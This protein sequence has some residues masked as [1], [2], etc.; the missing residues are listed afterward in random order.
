MGTSAIFQPIS[1]GLA[2]MERGQTLINFLDNNTLAP[3]GSFRS[4]GSSTASL[5]PK[6]ENAEL[7]T[8]ETPMRDLLDWPV[9][10]TDLE[11]DVS[12]MQ[13]SGEIMSLVHMSTPG[14]YIT[15]TIEATVAISVAS[16]GYKDI[17][18][19]F[20]TDGNI[21]R[22]ATL[23]E[24]TDGT[25]PLVAGVDYVLD[26][27]TGLVEIIKPTATNITFTATASVPAIV[28]G[29]AHQFV[30]ILSNP[31]LLASV[32]FRQNNRAG[33]NLE[34]V[35]PLVQFTPP[36]EIKLIGEDNS[37]S[38]TSFTGRVLYDARY[39]NSPRGWATKIGAALVS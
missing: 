7:R 6:V 8:S 26:A 9:V 18:R 5:K 10:Q 22:N 27:F 36:S 14:V 34:Y 31:A 12:A 15:Q 11:L 37:F 35:L 39:P 2:R 32:I 29:D 21:L 1:K 30:S 3:I 19:L 33:D 38:K 25:I 28:A 20:D 17:F 13:W 4:I 23:T 16:N 24:V